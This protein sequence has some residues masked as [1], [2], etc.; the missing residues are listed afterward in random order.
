MTTR[1]TLPVQTFDMQD[2]TS[3]M[4]YPVSLMHVIVYDTCVACGKELKD[5]LAMCIHDEEDAMM[6]Q[7]MCLGCFD[8]MVDAS[9]TRIIETRK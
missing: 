8:D 1:A 7:P 6:D 2:L 9:G 3:D 4:V 5:R